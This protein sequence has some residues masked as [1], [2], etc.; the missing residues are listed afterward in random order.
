MELSEHAQRNR[1]HWDST[2]GDW[3]EPGRRAWSQEEM[4]W[5]VWSVPESDLK[6]LDDVAGKDVLEAGCGTGYWSAWFTRR[7]ARPVGLDNS[8]K[9]LETARMLQKEHGLE[10]PLHLGTAEAMPFDDASFDMVFSE[11][12]ASIWCDPYLWIPEAVRVLRP[13][14]QLTFLV[15]STLAMLCAPDALEPP[16]DNLLRPLFGMHR[17]EWTDDNSVEFH[18]PHGKWIQLFREQGMDVEALIPLQAPADAKAHRYI[19][20]PQPEWGKKW[21]VEE[22]WSARRR[23]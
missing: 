11:Y 12:G 1:D 3:V 22:I 17:F 5:G 4:T 19:G 9:Q 10:F 6:V 2:A 7:G 14:G 21:P 15:N 18:L 23:H 13:G 8:P 20:L 16:S